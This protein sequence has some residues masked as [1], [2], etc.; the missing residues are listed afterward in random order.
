MSAARLFYVILKK[1]KVLYS[2]NE[3]ALRSEKRT[4]NGRPY[5][6]GFMFDVKMKNAVD[7]NG[8]G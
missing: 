7:L 6:V 2:L 8:A 5:G 3:G 1:E 4:A